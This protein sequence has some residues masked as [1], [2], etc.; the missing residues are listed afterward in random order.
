MDELSKRL[1]SLSPEQRAL[2]E[3]RLKKKGMAAPPTPAA[4]VIPKRSGEEAPLSFEQRQFWLLDQLEPGN[5]LYNESNLIRIRGAL[6]VEALRAGLEAIIQRHES[7]RTVFIE[8]E[9]PAQRVM[10]APTVEIPVVDLAALPP[11]RREEEA[12]LLAVREAELPFDLRRGPLFRAKLLRIEEAHHLLVLCVH[13]I[14]HDGYSWSVLL[15]ELGM[16][17]ASRQAGVAAGLPEVSVQYADYAAWQRQTI[18]AEELE[19][20][21]AYWQ[22]R[23]A[24]APALLEL[25]ADRARPTTRTFRGARHVFSLPTSLGRGLSELCRSEGVTPFMA[26]LAGFLALLHRYTGQADLVVGTPYGGSRQPELEGVIGCFVNT[27][28][29]RTSL[30]GD[31]SFQELLRRVRE[32]AL[33]AF[34]HGRLPFEKLV[35]RLAPERSPS[36]SPIFQVLFSYERT[37]GQLSLPGL[38][39]MLEELPRETSRLELSLSFFEGPEQLRAVI[40]YSTEL[41]EPARVR[42]MAE[43]LEVL[44]AAAFAAPSRR[45][46][47]L[48]LLT[49]AE[50]RSL[51]AWGAAPTFPVE[52]PSVLTRFEAQVARTPEA[53]AVLAEEGALTYAQLE[54]RANQL[55][56]R[57]RH[58]GVGP[59]GRVGLLLERSLDMVVAIL[60]TLKA[61]GAY[62]PLD[63]EHP[64]ER[65][66]A[67]IGDAA[68]RI[69]VSHRQ[70]A[71]RLSASTPMLELEVERGALERLP[72]QAPARH[73]EADH[74]AYVLY[75]SGSTGKPKGVMIPHGA[76]SNHMQ[77]MQRVFPLDAQA[78]VAQKTPFGFDASVWEFYAPLLAGG[79]LVMAGR[80]AHR[81]MGALVRML[82]ERQ[83]TVLQLVPT[84]LQR[85]LEEPGVE[86][87]RS[88]RRVLVGGEALPPELVR[89]L[90]ARLQVEVV[91]LYGPTE[92]TID[93]TTWSCTPAQ[94]DGRVS[95]GR[96]IDNLRAYV[97]DARMELVPEGIPGELYLGGAGLGRGYLGQPALTAERFVPDPLSGVPGARLYRT[98]DL[99][100]YLPNGELEYLGRADSQVKL[101]GHRIE[102]GEIEAAIRAYPGVSAATV[103]VAPTLS[104]E[105]GL[106]A[107]LVPSGEAVDVEVLRRFLKERLPPYMEPAAIVPMSALPMT[108]S[109]KVDHRALPSPE[110]GH[111]RSTGQYVAPRDP[112][113]EVVAGLW[114][115][116]L[117]LER[118]GVE[119]G[120]FELGGHSLLATRAVARARELFRT[121]LALRDLLEAPTVAGMA[122]VLRQR[123]SKPGLTAAAARAF[124]RLKKMT[125]EERQ[126]LLEAK[127][128]PRGG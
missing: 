116:V 8:R 2:L 30:E 49:E 89:R 16:L 52:A 56:H 29:L 36:H 103:R 3:L 92:T 51:I 91:N 69:V 79:V 17:Y 126:A 70:L 105:P 55:A 86:G 122:A 108:Y 94:W 5:P 80:D 117:G 26:L 42:R 98:G 61:G 76:L 19:R 6:D 71:S 32:T 67:V 99:V 120:F 57:L 115:E 109:G 24:G 101:R 118:V 45:V 34:S 11:E 1:A 53:P 78:R 107:Y 93:S 50:R 85:L 28:A 97:L 114:A 88:L 22:Q 72:T 27:L 33:G 12:R 13:H 106:I 84:V 58:A 87:C 44:L 15:R 112:V 54:Q 73:I 18:Q 81:D 111:F 77:W 63:P 123:E 41:F 125:P 127:K 20:W 128:G 7:L 121:E 31:P 25:P 66:A 60:A 43:H 119:E 68:P 40:E 64:S 100:R 113:E 46:S 96:P 10:S 82:Q 37:P 35:E 9:E 124:L 65:L 83:V 59:E 90:F 75:T 14:V 38:A 110:P 47:E 39:L 104:G 21:L 95:I 74:L 23:L 4:S 48:P 102:P 62:V